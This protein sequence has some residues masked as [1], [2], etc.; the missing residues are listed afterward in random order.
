MRLGN[1]RLCIY[2]PGFELEQEHAPQFWE[3][4]WK[5]RELKVLGSKS[6]GGLAHETGSRT[7]SDV[8]DITARYLFPF[9]IPFSQE[10]LRVSVP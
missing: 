1:G 4:G 3:L 6:P 5:Y 8:G 7:V 2:S 10:L 9:K